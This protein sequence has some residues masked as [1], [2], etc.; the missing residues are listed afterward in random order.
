M[1]KHEIRSTRAQGLCMNPRHHTT[2]FSCPDSLELH[3][4]TGGSVGL[5]LKVHWHK[6]GAPSRWEEKS[7][8]ATRSSSST[9]VPHD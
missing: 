6:P 5:A 4:P 7:M 2:P 3:V 8:H 1:Y 9:P